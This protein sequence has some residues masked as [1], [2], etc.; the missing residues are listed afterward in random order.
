MTLFRRSFRAILATAATVTAALLTTCVAAA[1]DRYDPS[2]YK[3]PIFPE[4]E[5][6]VQQ[7]FLPEAREWERIDVYVP[8]DSKDAERGGRLP[9]VV[10][11]YGGGWSGKVAGG[12]PKEM[13]ALL[14]RG[15]VVAMPDYVL[16]AAV[17]VP[18]AIWDGG[19]ALR[20][21]RRNAEKFRIDPERIGGWG[22]SAGGWLAQ[23]LAPSDFST[24]MPLEFKGLKRATPF[25]L[26]MLNPRWQD[27]GISP[28]LQA[29]ATDWGAEKLG[30]NRIIQADG[31]KWLDSNDPPLFTCHNDLTGKLPDGAQAYK[32]AGAIAEIAVLDVKN[33]H[34]PSGDTP[35]KTRDGKDSTWRDRTLDFF[36]EY[37]KYAKTPRN[38]AALAAAARA[39]HIKTT[40]LSYSAKAGEKF[41]V[42]FDAE[43]APGDAIEWVIAGKNGITQYNSNP[44]RAAPVFA[45]DPKTGVLTGT[46]ESPGTC[47]FLVAT[48]ARDAKNSKAVYADAISI[49]VTV[50]RSAV[51]AEKK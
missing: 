27:D 16:G 14:A 28:R 37:V 20:Y 19:E 25:Y 22:F 3:P 8:K 34:V 18:Q 39:G 33:T 10:I 5:C 48:N 51:P 1:V 41:E 30:K 11:F 24:L 49:T 29:F 46:P 13:K 26:P 17:P 42:K 45:I 43:A 23:Y 47:V 44:Q 7:K 40:Q 50:T 21:L 9:C 31:G 2:N 36:D 4:A 32:D 35:S 6:F 12:M 15:Y 38:I